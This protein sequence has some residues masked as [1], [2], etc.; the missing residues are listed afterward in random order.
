[1]TTG[2]I[3]GR[4]C[5]PHLGHSHLIDRAA[6]QVDQLVVFVNTRDDEPIPGELRAG[7][8]ADLHPDVTV[9]EVRHDLPTDFGDADEY[10]DRIA[11]RYGGQTMQELLE[12]SVVDHFRKAH[13]RDTFLKV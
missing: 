1:M 8:L 4:F 2:L 11:A 3:I 13:D 12:E 9:V 6:S 5:P 7:W 10:D